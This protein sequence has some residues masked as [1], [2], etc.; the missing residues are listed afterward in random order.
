LDEL[1]HVTA[2]GR[3]RMVDVGEKAVTRRSATA[4]GFL[5]LSPE[6]HAAVAS[7]AG[8]KGDVRFTAELAGIQGAKRT[9]DLVPLC[10]PLAIDAVDVEVTLLDHAL[11][12]VAT[13]RTAGR[14]GVEMEAMCAVQVA[15]LTAYDMLKAVD[16]ALEIG[17]VRLLAKSGGKSGDWVRGGQE[18][19]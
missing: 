17:P 14:T 19:R 2:D 6:A 1:T 16:R 5:S 15:L 13:V 3:P 4:E 8:K 18:V 12:C 9:S 7:R 10:H 11:R